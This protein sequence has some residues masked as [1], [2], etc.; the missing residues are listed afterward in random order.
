MSTALS[1]KT[2][3]G[4]QNAGAKRRFRVSCVASVAVLVKSS[5]ALPFDMDQVREGA[6]EKHLQNHFQNVLLAEGR[7]SPRS[8]WTLVKK[9]EN[10]S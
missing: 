3:S 6:L 7:P 5:S 4:V 2:S 10:N 1:P 8:F 9:K